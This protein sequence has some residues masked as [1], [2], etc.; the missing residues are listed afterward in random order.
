MTAAERKK[1]YAK[2]Y[3]QRP[4]TKARH[5][6]HHQKWLKANSEK[7]AA[8]TK[9]YNSRPEIMER[10]RIYSRNRKYNLEGYQKDLIKQ[11]VYRKTPKGRYVFLKSE[12]KRRNH[13]VTITFEE[14]CEICKRNCH[15]CGI[16]VEN[17]PALDRI[18]SSRGY[19]KDNVV[20]SC[21]RCNCAKNDMTVSEFKEWLRRI[22]EFS[23]LKN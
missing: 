12:A 19:E 13:I 2:E 6:I 22:Y 11:A 23:F 21:K 5:K 7:V 17:G 16:K 10:K 3:Y 9:E 15:Y 18:D 8:Y 14:Y 20:L 1:A 4:E